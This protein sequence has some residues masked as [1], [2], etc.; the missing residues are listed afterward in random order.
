[1]PTYQFICDTEKSGCGSLW[2][3]EASMSEISDIKPSCPQCKKRKPV[4]QDF[5]T[6]NVFGPDKT[7]GSLADKNTNKMSI[8]EK[9][10]IHAKNTAHLNQPYTGPLPEGAKTYKKT[11]TGE[12]IVE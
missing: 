1:M 6:I 7:L 2:E 3:L 5:S 11:L 10:I 4:H 9:A 8:D 12:R